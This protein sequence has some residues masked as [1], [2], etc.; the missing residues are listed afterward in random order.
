M[1]TMQTLD[2]FAM[3]IGLTFVVPFVFPETFGNGNAEFYKRLEEE[4]RARRLA[5]D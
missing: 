3:L 2:L 4:K 5:G 1:T